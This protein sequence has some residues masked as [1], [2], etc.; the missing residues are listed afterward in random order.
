MSQT[1]EDN[2]NQTQAVT[3]PQA[4]QNTNHPATQH[5][6]RRH[7]RRP[8]RRTTRPTHQPA[9]APQPTTLAMGI[10][11][12]TR[13]STR[14]APT[15]RA[16]QMAGNLQRRLVS[17]RHTIPTPHETTRATGPNRNRIHRPSHARHDP[18]P[19]RNKRKRGV[20]SERGGDI[21]KAH[22]P[23]HLTHLR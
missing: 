14:P 4:P 16:R 13:Q 7:R 10:I 1:K 15:T 17:P 11:P 19:N 23:P 5:L 18:R 12:R 8:K 6:P 20:P 22:H 9:H 3:S 21:R 2:D